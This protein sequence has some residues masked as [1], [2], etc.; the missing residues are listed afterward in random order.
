MEIIGKYYER[1]V[2]SLPENKRR[3]MDLPSW[4]DDVKVLNEIFGWVLKCGKEKIECRSEDEARYLYALWSFNWNDFWVPAD[5][6]Y[7]TEILPRLLKL[8]EGHDEVI[9]ERTSIYSNRKIGEELRRRTYLALT[10]REE[11]DNE[12]QD[13]ALSYEDEEEEHSSSEAS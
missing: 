9:E 12:E 11:E 10:L 6:K 2:L 8:K 5:D 7:L 13:E 1:T 3:Q 4:R